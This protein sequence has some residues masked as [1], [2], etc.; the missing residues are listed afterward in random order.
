MICLWFYADAL[1]IKYEWVYL[2][3]SKKAWIGL[4]DYFKIS[5][6][7]VLI[8]LLYKIHIFQFKF[9]IYIPFFLIFFLVCFGTLYFYIA[10]TYLSSYNSITNAIYRLILFDKKNVIFWG[11]FFR[12]GKN[13]NSP[14]A[15]PVKHPSLIA[16][17]TFSWRG[18]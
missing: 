5:F 6:V 12:N 7:S 14:S 11:H 10:C 15:F 1:D 16:F 8:K 13:V 17:L 4:F 9:I 3:A 18:I 2:W